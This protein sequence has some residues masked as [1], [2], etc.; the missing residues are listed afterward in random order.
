MLCPTRGTTWCWLLWN[1]L[2]GGSK[3]CR[4]PRTPCGW[5]TWPSSSSLVG[6]MCFGRGA[7][8]CCGKSTPHR[9]S[10]CSGWMTPRYPGC[11]AAPLLLWSQSVPR[12]DL[13]WWSL[14]ALHGTDATDLGIFLCGR[15]CG[16]EILIP[17]FSF[18]H[19]VGILLSSVKRLWNGCFSGDKYVLSSYLVPCFS[20]VHVKETEQTDTLLLH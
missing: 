20:E 9:Q 16:T 2:P 6:W 1:I 15:Q 12:E 11:G 8:V 13:Y 17:C 3:L 7:Q 5:R 19:Q 4:L 14:G 18:L 10:S